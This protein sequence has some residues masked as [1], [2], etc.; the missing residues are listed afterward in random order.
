MIKVEVLGTNDTGL[1]G[2]KLPKKEAVFVPREAILEQSREGVRLVVGVS[3]TRRPLEGLQNAF[4][5]SNGRVYGFAL[6]VFVRLK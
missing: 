4:E 6:D 2:Y 5:C 1:I 3:V